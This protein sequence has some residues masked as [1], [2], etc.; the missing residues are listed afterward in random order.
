MDN[1]DYE[2]SGQASKRRNEGFVVEAKPRQ[3]PT[4]DE[5]VAFSIEII[6]A[7]EEK[8]ETH[9]LEFPKRVTMLQLKKVFCNA[10][11]EYE[12]TEGISNTVW[13]FSRVNMYSRMVS[14]KVFKLKDVLEAEQNLTYNRFTEITALWIPL[15]EDFVEAALLVESKNLHYSFKKLDELYLTFQPTQ[16]FLY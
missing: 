16:P 15:E 10:V 14:G 8:V 11:T 13:A 6:K 12:E 7:L 2:F 4:Q 5:A 1:L 3:E 9:N